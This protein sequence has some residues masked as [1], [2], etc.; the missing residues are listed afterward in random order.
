MRE[1]IRRSSRRIAFCALTAALGTVLMCLGGLIPIATYCSP[2]L[3][4]LLMI[5][6]LEEYGRRE[7]WMV[8]AVTAMLSLLLSPDREAAFLYLFV[9]YY[10]ILRPF[11][12]TLKPRILSLSVKFLF[13]TLALGAMYALLI[14]VFQ[15]SE[16]L[17]E[18]RAA[19]LLLNLLFFVML[20]AVMMIYDL[21][22]G[23]LCLVYRY[24]IRPKLR[25]FS[26]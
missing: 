3:A 20:V 11:L 26:R 25:F 13:F 24:R 23:R 16:L 21:A 5:P 10:P 6:V 2:M 22:F 14:W 15:L 12:E 19:S 17:E 7:A 9:G 18:A 1:S 4:S 8:W